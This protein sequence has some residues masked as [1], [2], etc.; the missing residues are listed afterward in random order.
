[1]IPSIS[2]TAHLLPPLAPFTTSP[3]PSLPSISI[4]DTEP[5]VLLKSFW[6][7]KKGINNFSVHPSGK[8]ALSVSR[9]GC[10]AMFNFIRGKWSFCGRFGRE[11]TLVKFE[12]SGESFF[13]ISEKKVGV[14]VAEDARL[15]FELEIRKRVLCAAPGD[16]SS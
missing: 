13:M 5:F 15:L 14:H 10:L 7:H 11:A 8:L 1:M 9:D 4:F 6:A 3:T 16:V 12:V 2:S